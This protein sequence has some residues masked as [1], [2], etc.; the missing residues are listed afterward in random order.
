MSLQKVAI[1]LLVLLILASGFYFASRSGTD[2]QTYSNDFNVYYF[3][4]HEVIEGRNP[5]QNS[6]GEWT[7]YLYPPLLA[8]LILPLA[9][10]PLPVAAYLWF[11]ISAA[12]VLVAVWMSVMLVDSGKDQCISLYGRPSVAATLPDEST[13]GCQGRLPVQGVE[14]KLSEINYI[15]VSIAI[16]SLIVLAR[17]ILDNFELGQ[18]NTVVMMLAIAHIY[19][20]SKKRKLASSLALALAVSIKLTPALLIAYHLAKR[21]WRFAVQCSAMIVLLLT[22]SFAPF[23]SNASAAFSEFI[24]RTVRNEQGFDLAYAGN[25][26][27]RGALARRTDSTPEAEPSQSERRPTDAI[28]LTLSLLLLALAL[29]AAALARDTLSAVAPIFCC[30]ILLSPLAWKA[31][32]VM[33]LLPVV[34][35]VAS[36]QWS[37]VSGQQ[38]GV[39]KQKSGV[40]SRESRVWRKYLI[41]GLLA[42]LFC[43]FNLTSRRI[44]GLRVAEWADQ[45]SLIFAGAVLIFFVSVTMTLSNRKP[46]T[47]LTTDH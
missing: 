34:S 19:L 28:A 16:I 12:S 8:E 9:L 22:L 32:F 17:F 33:L 15:E 2:P 14:K 39:G 5:Y 46:H 10:L 27:L 45:H 1:A 38:S 29:I 24:N 30:M 36:G 23:G 44:I 47:S 43:M 25:Q 4:S 41:A 6:M 20:H 40:E 26:S 11:L 37:V 7:P 13:R 31:H 35:L 21:E 18:V 3:A 42:A